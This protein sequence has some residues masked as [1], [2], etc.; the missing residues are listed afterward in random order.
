MGKKTLPERAFQDSPY[1]DESGRPIGEYQPSA[2]ERL[3]RLHLESVETLR[4]ANLFT[5]LPLAAGA[6]GAGCASLLVASSGSVSA[7]LLGSW[8]VFVATAVVAM[9]RVARRAASAPIEL[10]SLRTAALD[11]NAVMLYAG[12]AWGAGAFIGLPVAAT[13]SSLLLFTIGGALALSIILRAKGA[14]LYFL[15]PN[16]ALAA[17]AALFGSAGLIASAMI[18]VLGGSVAAAIE[19]IGRFMTR[20]AYAPAIPSPTMS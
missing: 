14:A 17:A 20:R 12:F 16:I 11:L 7:I 2:L 15:F 4:L 3:T 6:M 1:S 10:P 18:L 19:I 9:L 5:R 13:M 8:A